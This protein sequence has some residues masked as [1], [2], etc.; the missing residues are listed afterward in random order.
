MRA[1]F[2]LQRT[3]VWAKLARRSQRGVAATKKEGVPDSVKSLLLFQD[4]NE[5]ER[6]RP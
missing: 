1:V 5:T 2:A 3:Q 4:D 6:E